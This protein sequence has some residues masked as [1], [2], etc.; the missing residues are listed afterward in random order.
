MLLR[1][2]PALLVVLSLAAFST[3]GAQQRAEEP[4]AAPPERLGSFDAWTAVAYGKAGQRVC[5][6]FA[7]ATAGGANRRR[8]TLTVAHWPRDRN[9][10]WLSAGVAY[11][12]TARGW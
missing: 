8:A 2:V 12:C 11:P 4:K 6:A 7:R 3:G 1:F 10:V 9:Q 5:Y